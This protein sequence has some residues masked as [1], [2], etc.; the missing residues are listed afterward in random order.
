MARA[1]SRVLSPIAVTSFDC[2]WS[3]AAR[4]N[5]TPKGCHRDQRIEIVQLLQQAMDVENT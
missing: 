1:I 3:T 5:A 2:G 4:H